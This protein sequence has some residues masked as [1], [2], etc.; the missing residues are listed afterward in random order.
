MSTAKIIISS[1]KSRHLPSPQSH[2]LR[3]SVLLLPPDT[4]LIKVNAPCSRFHA[5]NQPKNNR[6]SAE[7]Q[8]RISRNTIENQP[9]HNRKSKPT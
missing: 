2:L 9:K 7:K 1:I 4:E 5:K 3:L 6:E 8:S